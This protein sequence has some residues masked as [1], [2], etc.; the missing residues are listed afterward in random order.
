MQH[1][2]SKVFSEAARRAFAA[3]RRAAPQARSGLLAGTRLDTPGGWR[4]VETLQ[5]GDFVH[6]L[7]GTPKRVLRVDRTKLDGRAE[8]ENVKGSALVPA[9]V[10][11]ACTPFLALPD[12]HLLLHAPRARAVL[13]AD[14]ALVPGRALAGHLGIEPAQ[15]D[16]PIEVV[17]PV[18]EDEQAIWVNTGLLVHCPSLGAAAAPPLG[19]RFPA[20]T[21][22]GAEVL[23]ELLAHPAAPAAPSPFRGLKAKL[24]RRVK[25]A[26]ARA[27]RQ[28][29]TV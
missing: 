13:G 25:P 19:G 6:G 16:G 12:Q 28:A 9:G 22:R 10:F 21:G 26:G 4:P 14:F 11:G 5:P 2:N 23:M 18:F 20:L 15:P 3:A 27:R 7:D 8:L 17:T 29:A 24:P 1:Q